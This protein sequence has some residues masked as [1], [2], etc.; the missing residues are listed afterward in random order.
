[1]FDANKIASQKSTFLT[2][3]ER[4]GN[5]TGTGRERDGNG[6]GTGRERDGNG[7]GTG[8]ER[9]GN[10]TG[11]ERNWIAGKDWD[12]SN[13]NFLKEQEQNFYFC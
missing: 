9:D 4:D 11:T 13:E 3:W 8:R 2:V 7:T 1:M 5:G 10:G 12:S 6:T